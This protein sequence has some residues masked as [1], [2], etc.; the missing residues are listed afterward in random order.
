MQMMS[1]N[2]H[3]G[4]LHPTVRHV[5]WCAL[6]KNDAA[7]RLQEASMGSDGAVNAGDKDLLI[8]DKG[9]LTLS[10]TGSVSQRLFLLLA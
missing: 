5:S 6:H 2:L 7:H 1:R 4:L 3:Q 9:H 8:K 10:C